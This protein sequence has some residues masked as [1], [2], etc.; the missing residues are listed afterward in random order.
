MKTTIQAS[1]LSLAVLW[2]IAAPTAAQAIG[3]KGMLAGAIL[4]NLANLF[5]QT[6]TPLGIA[7]ANILGGLACNR[8]GY[9]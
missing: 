9:C 8:F 6:G 7:I 5:G 1:A 4:G 3:L 2:A